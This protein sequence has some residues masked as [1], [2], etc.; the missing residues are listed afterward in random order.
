MWYED[1]R[2]LYGGRL[3][4]AVG[5]VHAEDA[6]DDMESFSLFTIEVEQ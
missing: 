4:G 1:I 2:G 5:I 3:S 6:E